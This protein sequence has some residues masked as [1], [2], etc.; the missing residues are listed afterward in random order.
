MHALPHIIKIK[1]KV[2]SA[3][4]TIREKTKNN[5]SEKDKSKPILPSLS[6]RPR[7]IHT[8]TTESIQGHFYSATPRAG[9]GTKSLASL[10]AGPDL[11]F[12]AFLLV[13]LDMSS[14]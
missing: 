14:L 6:S 7:Q 2:K 3:C 5:Q 9:G 1:L 8:V 12:E 4:T 10:E 13:L 11:S